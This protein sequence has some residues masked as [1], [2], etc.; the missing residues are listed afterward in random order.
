MNMVT[1]VNDIV[2][3]DQ[4][5]NDEV[6]DQRDT[7]SQAVDELE[8]MIQAHTELEDTLRKQLADKVIESLVGYKMHE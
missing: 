8:H 6:S 3:L 5:V 1:L 2:E 7:D 4:K